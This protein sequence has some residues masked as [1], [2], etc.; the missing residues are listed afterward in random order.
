MDNQPF[1]PVISNY[2]PD[3]HSLKVALMLL[4]VNCK[5]RDIHNRYQFMLPEHIAQE[6]LEECNDAIMDAHVDL[7]DE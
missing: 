1:K 3:S 4:R 5:M 2:Q 6:I 7:P